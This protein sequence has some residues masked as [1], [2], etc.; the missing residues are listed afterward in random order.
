MN[1]R[2]GDPTQDDLGLLGQWGGIMQ[3][4]LAASLVFPL[5]ISLLPMFGPNR[6]LIAACVTLVSLAGN[7]VLLLL[8]S[9]G[10]RAADVMAAVDMSLV[11]TVVALIPDAYAAGVTL[12]VSLSALF[13]I[14]LG[15]KY[16]A[17][18]LVP[19]G[20]A[21]L[22]IGLTSDP[23]NWIASW[24]VWLLAAVFGTTIL[25]ALSSAT[26]QSF[27]RFDDLVNGIDAAVWESS[28]GSETPTYLSDR[29]SEVLGISLEDCLTPGF[30][31]SR[32][33]LD[34]LEAFRASR[35]EITAGNH[36][37]VHYRVHDSE[38]QTRSLHEKVVAERDDDGKIK[39]L[40]GV[41]VDE[42][43]RYVA[44]QSVRSYG[45]FIKGAPMAMA[46]FQLDDLDDHE[47]LR[48]LTCNQAAAN[49]VNTTVEAATG[50]RLI[51]L[52]DNSQILRRL[53]RVVL[54][55]TSLDVP[56]MRVD[57][58][59]S[60][61]SLRAMPLPDQCI[62]I[63]LEDITKVARTAETLRHQA[64]HDH[65]TGLP[66]RAHFS[67][68]L[69]SALKATSG[70][71]GLNENGAPQRSRSTDSAG[72][73]VDQVAVI[74]I[75]LNQFK[76]VNDTLGHEFGDRLLVD[77]SSRLARNLRGCDTIARLGG[78]E[79]AILIKSSDA[80]AS[81]DD[82]ARRVKDLCTEPFQIDAYRLKVG[83]SIGIA[84]HGEHSPDAL[85]L[86]R[87]ADSAM[88]QAKE[89]GGGILRYLSD[90]GELGS[91]KIT[92]ATELNRAVE[93]DE[94][95]V[96]YQP[97]IDLTSMEPVGV[98]ALIR[99]RHPERGLL[100]PK[101]FIDLAET[102]GVIR[103]LTR[104][105]TERAASELLDFQSDDGLRIN[106]NMSE[107]MLADPMFVRAISDIIDRTGVLGSSLCFELTED[108]LSSDPANALVVL[109]GL[110]A[111]GVRLSLDN[112]GVGHSSLSYLR[113]LP[114]D[115]VK[116]DQSFIADMSE[117]DETIVRTVIEMGH[118]LGL[119]VVAEGVE[120]EQLV[121]RLQEL[122]CDSAQGFHLARPMDI[123]E[124]RE[125]LEPGRVPT[126]RAS[127]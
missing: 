66:N 17:R 68:R 36:T 48:V 61:Y 27:N 26:R 90:N 51:E 52:I 121:R 78:D 79:F 127:E 125:F 110:R 33:H 11:V 22:V 124:L 77:L 123:D 112:F 56:D 7:V 23:V 8:T 50:A 73:A 45:E 101:K 35:R 31:E 46:I 44:E 16:T 53:A 80:A 91:S 111:L 92:L 14:W 38:G 57:S 113:D 86:M 105:V 98:E 116:I 126:L 72:A 34:D 2:R 81:A 99:W 60:I 5:I 96:H 82:V 74:M 63:S 18:M 64:L 43:A 54:L 71:P 37:E 67:E 97:R 103:Q 100:P 69:N 21:L 109:H 30:V 89:S 47:S 1:G 70:G 12:I 62:G 58:S 19:T 119:H 76:D 13:A 25:S 108:D 122:G 114:L 55:N 49:I 95:V 120:S 32:V 41:I 106:I 88:Y 3:T 107:R 117:G 94:F 4:R 59:S 104:M 75:D 20:L 39:C 24:L 9:R 65:L 28:A 42:T 87:N 6:L 15:W 115:E 83:A 40:R 93:L 29:I 84:V 10:R 118:S 102:S 85:S